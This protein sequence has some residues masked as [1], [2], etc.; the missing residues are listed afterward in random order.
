[1][2]ARGSAVELSGIVARARIMIQPRCL[3][4]TY[5]SVKPNDSFKLTHKAL[6][7]ALSD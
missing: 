2:N 3:Y 6:V 5:V 7:A 1:M 4:C